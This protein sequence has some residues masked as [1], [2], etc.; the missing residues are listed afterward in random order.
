MDVLITGIYILITGFLLGATYSLISM[1]LALQY[2]VAR[3]MNLAN[4]E[5]FIAGALVAFWVV[6]SHQLSPYVSLLFVVPGA[7]V[8]NWLIYR[9]LLRPL[10]RRAKHGG[11]LEVD[12]IL[13]TFGMGFILVGVLREVFGGELFSYSYL[14]EPIKILNN[15]FALNR[16]IGCLV[17]VLICGLLYLGYYKTRGGMAMRAVAADPSAAG[18]VAIDVP[19]ISAFSFALGG[20]VT[21]AGGVVISTFLPD[22]DPSQGVVFTLKALIV[23]IMGGVGDLR[24]AIVASFI[25]GLTETLVATLVDP[26]FILAAAYLLFVLVLLFRPQGLFGRRRA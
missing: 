11:Q 20:A 9:Y 15:N 26:G 10:V 24:G 8:I 3:I 7:F 4:G 16:V 2:G 17:S 23:V 25:L 22:M 14:L 18:L 12:S 13:A 6:T 5:M 19:K 21:A 1:G